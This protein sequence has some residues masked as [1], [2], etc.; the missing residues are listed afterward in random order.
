VELG[1]IDEDYAQISAGLE[2]GDTVVVSAQ[3]LLDS[4]SSK[5]A[6]LMRMDSTAPALTA[7][8]VGAAGAPQHGKGGTHD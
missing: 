7:A 4:E 1:R 2:A 3:F 8:E 6:D 5:S